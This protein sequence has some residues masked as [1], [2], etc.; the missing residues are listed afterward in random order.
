MELPLETEVVDFFVG[1][2]TTVTNIIFGPQGMAAL[3]IMLAAAASFY[4]VNKIGN[5]G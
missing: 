1:S 3:F 2:Q 5:K 4:Y